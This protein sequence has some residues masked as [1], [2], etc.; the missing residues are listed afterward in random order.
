M[1]S[2]KSKLKHWLN[3]D[4]H[5]TSYSGPPLFICLI[6]STAKGLTLLFRFPGALLLLPISFSIF[7]C[8]WGSRSWRSS[9]SRS[10]AP[11][12]FTFFSTLFLPI[13][14]TPPWACYKYRKTL[15]PPLSC[16]TSSLPGFKQICPAPTAWF[17]DSP[18]RQEAVRCWQPNAEFNFT[19]K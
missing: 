18:S 12:C 9:R 16:S 6:L 5:L 4:F 1:D 17:T 8:W 13:I 15:K 7:R 19:V 11:N 10:W 2:I 3:C 14:S